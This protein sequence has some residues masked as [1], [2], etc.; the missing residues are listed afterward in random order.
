[1]SDSLA[2]AIG[3]AFVVY[4]STNIDDLLLLAVFF[5]DPHVRISAV[6]AG[7]YIGLAALVLGSGA[8]ALMAL[9]IPAQWIALL[10]LIPLYLGLRALVDVLRDRRDDASDAVALNVEARPASPKGFTSQALAVAGVTLANG[11][12]N[13]G[14][15]IPLFATAP[16]AM[17][18][19]IAVF[20]LM[21]AV[22]CA[23]GYVI[24]NN[25]LIGSQVRRYGHLLL[26]VVLIGLGLYILSGAVALVR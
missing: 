5:A 14:I 6:V 7:R 15:Y 19:Y 8:A 26:P 11:G 18:I 16:A 9:A 25:P 23:L 22:W 24:V 10:G 17:P 12:D 13:F 21:T 2:S 3:I 20:A 4:A 1:V